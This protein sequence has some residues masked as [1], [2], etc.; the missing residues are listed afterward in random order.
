MF[1]SFSVTVI[2]PAEGFDE[3]EL[4]R[5]S[6]SLERGS[7][8]PLAD[9]IVRAAA[10]RGLTVSEASEFDSPVGRGVT[11]LVELAPGVTVAD[12]RAA[13]GP[14]IVDATDG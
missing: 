5:L 14:A 10:D 4:L 9:A 12:V 13:T 3:G 8:H 11:G 7:E 1:R 2:K 6:A